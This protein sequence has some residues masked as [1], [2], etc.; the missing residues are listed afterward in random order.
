MSFT[1]LLIVINVIHNI[2]KS[3]YQVILSDIND[4][5]NVINRKIPF[6]AKSMT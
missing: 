4:I 2:I 6:Q 3:V 1:M 5:V